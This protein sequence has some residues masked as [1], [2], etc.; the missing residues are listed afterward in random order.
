MELSLRGESLVL[1]YKVVVTT[2]GN[3]RL[4]VGLQRL[5]Q[6]E[7]ARGNPART[8]ARPA[9]PQPLWVQLPQRRAQEPLA[10]TAAS[11]TDLELQ[12]DGRCAR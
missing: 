7:P 8:S 2:E 11:P 9:L 3:S 5:S 12:E 4:T 10:F 6:K 1:L